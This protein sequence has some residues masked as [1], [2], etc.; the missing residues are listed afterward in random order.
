MQHG[1]PTLA[2][3]R[4]VAKSEVSFDGLDSYRI[5]NCQGRLIY[6]A[7]VPTELA[8]PMYEAEL[9][10]RVARWCPADGHNPA[11]CPSARQ[12]PVA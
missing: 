7:A 12:I 8:D 2:H 6:L 1:T 10:A 5:F 3:L 9:E 4:G 11:T